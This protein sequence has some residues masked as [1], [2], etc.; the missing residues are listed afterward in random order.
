VDLARRLYDR[1]LPHAQDLGSASEL[2]GL[3]DII[4]NGDGAHRQKLVYD[5]NHDFVELMR[6]IVD[7]TAG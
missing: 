3:L 5:A 2:E 6:D 4:E 7:V 1:L